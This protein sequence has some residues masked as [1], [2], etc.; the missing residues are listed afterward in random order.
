M[1]GL[2]METEFM[3]AVGYAGEQVTVTG[4]TGF[5]G[6]HL[7]RRLLGLGAKVS[8]LARDASRLDPALRQVCSVVQGDL[9]DP[10]AVE[11]ALAG[12]AYVFHCAANVAT[13]GRWE[14]YHA[15]N[16]QGV[17]TLLDVLASDRAELKRLVHL[18]TLDVYG[19]PNEPANES[20]SLRPV[21][22]GYG[23]SK[24]M[25]EALVHERC[26]RSGVP[27][28]ILR[29]GNIVGSGSPFV[30]RIGEQLVSGLMLTIDGGRSHAGLIDVENLL[31]VLLWAG[32]SPSA[33]QQ[34]YNV[35]DFWDVSWAEYVRDLKNGLQGKGWVVDLNY[36]AATA[37]GYL[38]SAPYRLFGLRREPRLHPLIVQLFGRTCA[39]S[40]DKLLRDGAPVGRVD[41]QASLERSLAWF[42]DASRN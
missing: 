2:A 19:F 1:A 34:V 33:E 27:Y 16:V 13:W 35:R 17:E 26:A 39:H 3:S 29:P 25:G 21:R 24:R 9:L 22:L 42:I 18:S 36:P 10:V 23:E 38:L 37:A 32:L 11:Q 15:A 14:D 41:Y 7:V 8:V 4:A 6:G 5:V 28:S 40:I 31:D 12:S 20:A 30:S